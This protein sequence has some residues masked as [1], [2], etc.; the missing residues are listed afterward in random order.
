MSS[1]PLLEDATLNSGYFSGPVAVFRQRCIS[2]GCES[3]EKDGC[4]KLVQDVC[5]KLRI[6]HRTGRATRVRAECLKLH[7]GTLPAAWLAPGSLFADNMYHMD[8]SNNRLHGSIPAVMG[9]NFL[10]GR[11]D[12]EWTASAV[13][14]PM[15]DGYGLCGAV[16]NNTNITDRDTQSLTGSQPWRPCPAGER[17]ECTRHAQHAHDSR[18]VCAMPSALQ[19]RD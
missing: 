9:G 11:S 2:P 12:S 13:L 19:A 4:C 7:A 1:S 3:I 5:Q 16:P 8:L 18:C 10:A 6:D 17:A 14:S 15:T